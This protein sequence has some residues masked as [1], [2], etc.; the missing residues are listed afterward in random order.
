M[1]D[2]TGEKFDKKQCGAQKGRSTTHAL[3]D[4]MHCWHKLRHLTTNSR[5]ESF[6]STTPRHSTTW[7]IEQCCLSWLN[8]VHINSLSAGCIPSWTTANIGSRSVSE[9]LSPNGG[10]PQGMWLRVCVFLT[11]IND[12]KSTLNLR[13]GEWLYPIWGP[14]KT[15]CEFMPPEIDDLNWI[16][17]QKTTYWPHKQAMPAALRLT[18]NEI[19]TWPAYKQQSHLQWL[20]DV[21][22][23]KNYQTPTF[24]KT[25]ETSCNV[26]RWF[27]TQY[28][29]YY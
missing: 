25:V 24:L 17:G 16:S 23:Y 1:V 5:L 2:T 3:V 4:M 7:I 10:M 21:N 29:H 26:Y 27:V 13:I 20:C 22:I 11:L 18:D 15:C 9:W 8:L 12:L 14:S 19:V 6:L 28:L